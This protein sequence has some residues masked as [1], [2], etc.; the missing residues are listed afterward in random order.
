VPA[1][2]IAVAV[3]VTL[4]G[5]GFGAMRVL[6]ALKRSSTAAETAGLSKRRLDETRAAL[7]P[8]TSAPSAAD[9]LVKTERAA[10]DALE[11]TEAWARG[12]AEETAAARTRFYEIW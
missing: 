4:A 6:D 11:A 5:L 10:R 2:A 3:L 9:A 7:A 8:T 1:S 12:H